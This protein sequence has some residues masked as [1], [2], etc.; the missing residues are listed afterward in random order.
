MKFLSNKKI[1][2]IVGIALL[3]IAVIVV[4]LQKRETPTS[5]TSLAEVVPGQT[6]ADQVS[7]I[8]GIYHQQESGD[9]KTIFFGNNAPKQY[10]EVV[11][12]NGIILGYKKT[13]PSTFQFLN[14]D[15]YFTKYG[16]T[17]WTLT[18]DSSEF[19][20]KGYVF[21]AAGI[22]VIGHEYNREV[23]EEWI[24]EKNVSQ[25]TINYLFPVP[26]QKIGH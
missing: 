13:S 22:V 20:F 16:Q 19:G 1:L 24:V 2:F 15:D 6:K 14:L 21:S 26:T 5:L 9:T 25:E 12:K 18:T 3:L 10:S 4:S 8:P 7:N 11:A 23:I 17:S